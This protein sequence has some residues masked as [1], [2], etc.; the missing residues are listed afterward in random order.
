MCYI[1]FGVFNSWEF[2][3]DLN[4]H[5]SVPPTPQGRPGEGAGGLRGGLSPIPTKIIC[6]IASGVSI[7]LNSKMIFIFITPNPHKGVGIG[8]LEGS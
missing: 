6:Y 4:F 2:K 1:N 7:V 8:D 3:N 5:F